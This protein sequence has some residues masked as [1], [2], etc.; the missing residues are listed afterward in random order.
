MPEMTWKMTL[1]VT[2]AIHTHDPIRAR[3]CWQDVKPASLNRSTG[4]RH[5]SG[6]VSFHVNKQMSSILPSIIAINRC[7][8]VFGTTVY[9][10]T[11]SLYPAS[12]SG[13]RCCNSKCCHAIWNAPPP[14][15]QSSQIAIGA[16]VKEVNCIHRGHAS[17]TLLSNQF[18]VVLEHLR[19]WKQISVMNVE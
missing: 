8:H 3:W 15:L 2:V 18:K 6:A 5:F 13:V 10:H 4:D 19:Y 17:D 9:Y 1:K 14:P 12:R 11:A 16:Q 7:L